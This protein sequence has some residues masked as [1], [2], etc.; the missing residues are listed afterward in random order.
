MRLARK[1]FLGFLFMKQVRK[2]N[3]LLYSSSA[4][5]VV[6]GK[7]AAMSCSELLVQEYASLFQLPILPTPTGRGIIPDTSRF[8][9]SSVRSWALREADTVL[10]LGCR[11]NWMLHFGDPP[12]WK[13]DVR[14]ILVDVDPSGAEDA[15]VSIPS[16]S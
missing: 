12:R 6:V 7:G 4:P 14:F 10:L 2:M 13:P 15:R 5:L 11:L 8:C 1:R 9:V 3:D 16:V